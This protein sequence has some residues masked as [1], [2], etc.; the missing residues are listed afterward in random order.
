MSAYN[1]KKRWE[2]QLRDGSKQ[3]TLRKVRKDE[4]RPKVGEPFSAFVG[5][6]TKSCRRLFDSTIQSVACIDIEAIHPESEFE[7]LDYIILRDGVLMVG[8]EANRMAQRDG[9]EDLDHF[10][11]FFEVEHLIHAIPFSGH[12]IEWAPREALAL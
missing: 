9:F 2:S 3:T 12:L 8:A 7:P 1:F 10:I 5:M 4:R 6:R 11:S